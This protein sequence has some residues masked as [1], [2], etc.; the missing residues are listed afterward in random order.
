MLYKFHAVFETLNN[1]VIFIEKL[2]RVTKFI[3]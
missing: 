3:F 2:V 1:I